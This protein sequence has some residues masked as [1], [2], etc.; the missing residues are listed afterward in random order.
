MFEEDGGS[1]DQKGSEMGQDW[2][3]WGSDLGSVTSLSLLFFIAVT[4]VK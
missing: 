4:V 2:E 3:G 1:L